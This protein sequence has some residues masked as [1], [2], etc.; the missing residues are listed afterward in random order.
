MCFWDDGT[1]GFLVQEFLGKNVLVVL[2]KGTVSRGASET[3]EL[4]VVGGAVA[5]LDQE[6]LGKK[7]VVVLTVLV[8]PE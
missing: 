3:M 4:G 1:V 7:V 5:N 6:F 8:F 2:S